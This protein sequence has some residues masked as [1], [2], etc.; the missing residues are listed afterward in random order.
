MSRSKEVDRRGGEQFVRE[1][2]YLLGDGVCVV[3]AQANA[4]ALKG[5]ITPWVAH[6]DAVVRLSFSWKWVVSLGHYLEVPPPWKSK[7][8]AGK[9]RQHQLDR[10]N[11]ASPAP[12]LIPIGIQA[13]D[14]IPNCS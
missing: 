14:M 8:P 11:G 7:C 6:L 4:H 12:A 9:D 2:A 13:N 10:V 5:Q 3:I 1:N